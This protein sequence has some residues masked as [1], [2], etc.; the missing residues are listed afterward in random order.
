[1]KRLFVTAIIVATALTAVA[2]N[3]KTQHSS[4]VDLTGNSDIDE[5]KK[6]LA[7]HF[8]GKGAGQKDLIKALKP[9]SITEITSIRKCVT[10]YP[11]WLSSSDLNRAFWLMVSL[12]ETTNTGIDARINANV[13]A[14]AADAIAKNT[15][16]QISYWHD[17]YN[18]LEDRYEKLA[19]K[20]SLL[21]NANKALTNALLT[22]RVVGAPAPVMPSYQTPSYQYPPDNEMHC[23]THQIGEF[24]KTDCY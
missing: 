23:T 13:N 24:V 12:S 8:R 7:E 6:I 17:S 18:A 5:C 19:Y 10:N 9:E 14:R 1:M 3:A 16:V 22:P 15:D 21:E 11:D 2:Q 4:V 20:Y